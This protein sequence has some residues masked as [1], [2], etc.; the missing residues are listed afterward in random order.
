[1]SAKIRNRA[2]TVARIGIRSGRSRNTKSK[3][4]KTI[5]TRD[6]NAVVAFGTASSGG[7]QE[8]PDLFIHPSDRAR[9]AATKKPALLTKSARGPYLTAE[10]ATSAKAGSINIFTAA[11]LCLV[12]YCI[13]A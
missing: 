11:R 13:A 9:V 4:N 1:M 8:D 6:A 7:T 12:E 3:A 10:L 5:V 2:V